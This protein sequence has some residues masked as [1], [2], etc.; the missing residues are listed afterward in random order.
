MNPIIKG[1][2]VFVAS[3]IAYSSFI[4]IKK[5][6]IA[7]ISGISPRFSTIKNKIG[8]RVTNT[9]KSEIVNNGIHIKNP[10]DNVNH[11][12][13]KKRFIRGEI[14]TSGDTKMAF[15]LKFH[16]NPNHKFS[17]EDLIEMCKVSKDG[18]INIDEF[19]NKYIEKL[20]AEACIGLYT[21]NILNG[22]IKNAIIKIALDKGLIIDDITLH[23]IKTLDEYLN[24]T[25]IF[26]KSNIPLG[27]IINY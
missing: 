2:T 4:Y 16:L 21:G 18:V 17:T 12:S 22:I 25:I 14:Q 13:C 27:V 7:Q 15:S 26:N 23:K 11:I 6:E 19:N 5:D 10:F 9:F 24:N 1:T 20:I 8:I 3:C